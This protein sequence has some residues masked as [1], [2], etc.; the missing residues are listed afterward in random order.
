MHLEDR[1][2]MRDNYQEARIQEHTALCRRDT[3]RE[4]ID[5]TIQEIKFRET[6]LEI[7]LPGNT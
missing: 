3:E 6:L 5:E 7:E 1:I 4:N 2:A